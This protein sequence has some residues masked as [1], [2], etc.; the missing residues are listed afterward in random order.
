[1][2]RHL[3]I[4][5]AAILLAASVIP[6][7][8]G[9]VLQ[10]VKKIGV[11]WPVGTWGWM[12]FVSFSPDGTK[13]ASDGTTEPGGGGSG[14]L[15]IWSFPRGKLLK[16]LPGQLQAMSP[17][18]RY[19][20]D[21]TGIRDMR[22]G[23]TVVAMPNP[24]YAVRTF[25]TGGRYVAVEQDKAKPGARI[26]IFALPGG[27]PVAAFAS[28]AVY[29][30]AFSPGGARLAS[31]GWDTVTL[32]NPR[33]GSRMGALHGFGRYVSGI[34]FSP[35]GKLLAVGTDWGELQIWDLRHR[36]K[37]H[38]VA[39]DGAYPAIAFSPNGRMIAA[40]VY[41]TGTAWLIDVRSGKVLDHK[42]VSSLGCGG[43]AFSPDSRYLI[44]PSTGGLITWPWDIGGTIRVFRI[45]S[46]L[47]SPAPA[48][49]R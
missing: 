19:Y 39:L 14:D 45:A 6:A 38:A 23:A 20:A 44:T 43:V 36:K 28:H 1:M 40:G 29:A 15:T 5:L 17:D 3:R 41:G 16:R 32:W 35:D 31:G 24:G 18:W 48:P 37:L 21:Q 46:A 11:S 12:S 13:V 2:N 27:K 9:G 22:T 33:N 30:L 34:A 25:S 8:S 4:A 47:P 7:S 10:P 26:A 42:R 49:S